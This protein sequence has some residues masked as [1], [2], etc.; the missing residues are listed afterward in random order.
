MKVL[1]AQSCPT[2][3][4]W[5]LQARIL[6]WVTIPFSTWPFWPRIWTWVFCIAGRFFTIWTIKK[7]FINRYCQLVTLSFKHS[8][9][10]YITLWL[11]PDLFCT[12]YFLSLLCIIT[13]III[14]FL[15][16]CLREQMY[17]IKDI[18]MSTKVH[19]H[20]HTHS[21]VSFSILE[22][23]RKS[24]F[25]FAINHLRSTMS[26]NLILFIKCMQYEWQ[27]YRDNGKY[28]KNNIASDLKTQITLLKRK[29]F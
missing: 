24:W 26:T 23:S 8:Y 16:L 27:C 10:I 20:T 15:I 21:E 19:T 9:Y 14:T 7:P 17:F 22:A 29:P 6:K 11:F 28:G 2:L 25:G 1:V 12:H 13:T 5:I 4:Y 3:F 18:I